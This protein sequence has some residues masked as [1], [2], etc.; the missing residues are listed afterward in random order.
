MNKSYF[1]AI[2]CG[3]LLMSGSLLAQDFVKMDKSPLDVAYYPSNSAFRA[4]EKDEKKRAQAEPVMRII[5]SRPHMNDRAIFG[6]SED[7]LIKFGKVW[8]LGAN[9]NAELVVMKSVNVGGQTVE[10]GRYSL[11]AIPD[12]D[13]WTLIINSE[14]DGWG[15]YSYDESKDVAR[16][17]AGVYPLE[18]AVEAF[19]MVFRDHSLQM[20]WEKTMVSIPVNPASGMDRLDKSPLDM[21]YYPARAPFRAFEK[22]EAK[23]AKQAPVMRI[24][25]SRPQANGRSLFGSSED[26][27][28]KFGEVW[29]LGA[30]ESA[31]LQVIRTAKIGGKVVDPGRYGVYVIPGESSWTLIVNKD[32]DGWGAYAYDESNDVMRV[33]GTV[34]SLDE[35]VE[36]LS[37]QFNEEALLIAWGKTL[38]S[39]PVK[40]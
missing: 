34:S 20:A 39:F 36:A 11:H 19:S 16:I 23:R 35:A 31:E 4:F 40:G 12:K 18:E 22:D 13:H 30:N 37:V 15:S 14:V 5:Y 28:V 26:D 2:L 7:H 29:R 21:S 9:E 27:L 33:E 3:L 1:V 6:S 24:V 38:V 17:M 25:Y 8:R 32:L 10:P